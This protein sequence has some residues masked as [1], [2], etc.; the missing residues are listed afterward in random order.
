MCESLSCVVHMS[1]LF[2]HILG[3]VSDLWCPFGF[4]PHF[5]FLCLPPRA[6]VSRR[7]GTW[8]FSRVWRGT[9]LLLPWVCSKSPSPRC[10]LFCFD[11]SFIFLC[12]SGFSCWSKH[13]G[14]MAAMAPLV[15]FDVGICFLVHGSMEPA[16]VRPPPLLFLAS[17]WPPL[18]PPCPSSAPRT[19]RSLPP[20]P[21][22]LR[23]TRRPPGRLVA[24]RLLR[25]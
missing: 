5:H 24:A 11:S 21:A 8:R 10:G 12:F 9:L 6:V 7:Q 23:P 4:L 3:V 25:R 13:G 17:P 22:L 19:P 1:M 2:F 14:S 16:P 20:V 15:L 18:S